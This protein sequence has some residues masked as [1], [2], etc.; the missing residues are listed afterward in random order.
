MKQIISVMS[1][2]LCLS[3]ISLGGEKENK[4]NSAKEKTKV[5]NCEKKDSG[6][7]CCSSEKAESKGCC[8]TDKEKSPKK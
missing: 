4:T 5:T 6:K 8:K 1:V 3:L 2:V 7:S